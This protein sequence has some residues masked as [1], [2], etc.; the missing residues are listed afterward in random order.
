MAVLS[1]EHGHWS[2][3]HTVVCRISAVGT[4]VDP[5]AKFFCSWQ[6]IS[7]ELNVLRKDRA[8]AFSLFEQLLGG[9]GD[10]IGSTGLSN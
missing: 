9:G 2:E 10:A 4:D 8:S 3:F 7:T 1:L 6:L 5:F